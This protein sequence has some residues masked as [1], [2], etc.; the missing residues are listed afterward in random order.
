MSG[1]GKQGNRSK[2]QKRDSSGRGNGKPK[3]NPKKSVGDYVFYLGSSKQASDY[4]TTA[5]YLINYIQETFDYGQDIAESLSTL[6]DVD[7]SVY[8]PK[9]E[10]SSSKDDNKREAED[11]QYE[12]EFK[13][14]FAQYMRREEAFSKNQSKAF[15]FLIDHCSKGMKEKIQSR[16]D[17]ITK[18]KN[19]PQ[20]LLKAIKQHALNFEESRYDMAIVHDAFKTMFSTVQKDGESLQDYTKRFRVAKEVL[21]SHI[22]GP[23]ILS[24]IAKSMPNYNDSDAKRTLCEKSAYERYMAY[25]YL[26]NADQGKYGSILTGLSTQ[27]SLGNN[28]YPKTISDA[29]SVLSNHPF[30]NYKK[31]KN[32]SKPQETKGKA[33][34]EEVKLS[35]AQAETVC[36]C[37]G[38]PNHKSNVCRQKDKIPREEWA[39]NKNPEIKKHAQ[40]H[41]QSQTKET[42]GTAE[43]TNNNETGSGQKVQSWAGVHFNFHQGEDDMRNIILLDNQSTATVFCNE[44][45]VENIRETKDT[46]YLSTNGGVMV[47]NLKANIPGWGVAWFNPK[48]VTNIFSFA[49]MK[50]RYRIDYSNEEDAFIVHLPHRDVKFTRNNIGLYVYRPTLRNNHKHDMQFVTTLEENKTFYTP[51]QFERAKMARDLYHAVGTPSIEDFKAI[52]KINAIKNNP[53]TTDDILLAEKIFGPDIGT[54]KGKTT[55]RKPMPVISDYIEIPK[56]LIEAQ[57]EVTLCMDAMKVNGLW[58]LTTISRN[59]YYRTAQYVESQTVNCYREALREIIRIYNRAGFQVRRIHCDNEFANIMNELVNDGELDIEINYANSQEHVPEAERNNR[60]L[61]ERVRAVY[62]RIP[63]DRLPRVMVIMMVTEAARKLNF[64][65]AK[66]GVS[67]YY[68]PR[69][70]M[71]HQN[72]DYEKHCKFSF[73][74]Y[75]Q[76]HDEPQPSNTQQARTLDCIYLR[77]AAN[78]QGGHECFHIPTNRTIMSSYSNPNN[79]ICYQGS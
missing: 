63:Y 60:V 56:E 76:A 24:K 32:G 28:Q 16:S 54:L 21:E 73:G 53:V 10:V 68:S 39:V 15:A 27:K 29:T 51:R 42:T 36:Y 12:I 17:Y 23:L 47:S 74:T 30:D 69:M 31:D 52:I 40:A 48:A 66:Y 55:R 70:I 44:E 26:K 1:R 2:D 38:K 19:K 8:K 22:G 5:E 61:K 49:E 65:P 37:C 6:E 46:L 7:L 41:V 57:R 50:D 13:E 58:F 20:E 43:T 25:V 18:I 79:T 77:P 33:G 75:V 3:P 64:F 9:L 35:F 71:H 11:K 67:K 14:K 72:L 59:I 34:D 45:M 78:A 62:H 4:E